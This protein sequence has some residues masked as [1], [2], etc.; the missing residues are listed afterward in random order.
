MYRVVLFILIYSQI[1]YSKVLI[2]TY[3]Y[4]RPDFI[5]T[6]YK[7]FKK[8]LL[9]EY[10]FIVFNDAIKV[11]MIKK[12]NTMCKKY[13][14]RCVRIPQAIHNMPYLDK[15]PKNHNLAR[16]HFC[17][18]RNCNV[19][20][21]SLDIL[22][23]DHDDI[24]ALFDSDIF[25]I[26]EFS[27]SQF[28]HNHKLAGPMVPC[29]QTFWPHDCAKFHPDIKPFEYIWIGLVFLDM[30]QITNKTAINFNCGF[31]H[32]NIKVDAGGYTYYLFKSS[33][34]TPKNISRISLGTLLCDACK[35]IS[36][37]QS[38]CTHN[39]DTLKEIGLTDRT[40]QLAQAMPLL[41]AKE[42]RYIEF[43]LYGTLI[44]YRGGTN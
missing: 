8:F 24:V 40:I 9:D 6:Q 30:S 25:L 21:Y 4:N 37:P 19:V 16:F 13:N 28:L 42:G 14:I 23:V 39:T 12:I 5:E 29:S 27:I 7:T 33:G 22:G 35:G 44:H 36:N 31:V 10:E 17:S 11:D 15:S 32:N 41:N 38:S 26:K 20:Q 34:V 18:V 2:F 3:A 1:C 43:L